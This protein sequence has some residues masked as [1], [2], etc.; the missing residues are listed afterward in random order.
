MGTVNNCPCCNQEPNTHYLLHSGLVLCDTKE[1]PLSQKMCLIEHWNNFPRHPAEK[2]LAELKNKIKEFV[3]WVNIDP[4]NKLG[5]K[6]LEIFGD[7]K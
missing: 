2:E 1:C 3:G 7:E 6:F 5:D 4:K